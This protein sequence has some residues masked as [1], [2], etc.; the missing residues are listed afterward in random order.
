MAG[1]YLLATRMSPPLFVLN[2]AENLFDAP[3]YCA[4]Q[5][6][7]VLLKL[8]DPF[9][10]VGYICDPQNRATAD[11]NFLVCEAHSPTKAGGGFRFAA[12]ESGVP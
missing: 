10:A 4:T 2:D 9:V 11:F 1:R 7:L 8:S 5:R 12:V 3:P 6:F